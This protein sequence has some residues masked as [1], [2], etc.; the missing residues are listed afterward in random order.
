MTFNLQIPKRSSCCCHGQE[1][2]SEGM[3]Y[4]SFI[5]RDKENIYLRNDYCKTCWKEMQSSEKTFWKGKIQPKLK[6]ELKSSEETALL[7][8]EDIL[9]SG[10]KKQEAF[11]LALY[12]VRKKILA[13]RKSIDGFD[14][15]EKLETEEMLAIPKVPIAELNL[16]DLQKSLAEKLQNG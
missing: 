16:A 7:Y 9:T 3:E 2:F 5:Q 12:L 4:Y 8:L 6:D 13:F 15:Y 1:P 10:D 11:I 14:L